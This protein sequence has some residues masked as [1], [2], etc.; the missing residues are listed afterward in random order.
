[1]ALEPD[2]CNLMLHEND[3]D[4]ARQCS[5]LRSRECVSA[6]ND[7]AQRV[8]QSEYW[9]TTDLDRGRAGD[10]SSAEADNGTASASLSGN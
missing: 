10:R 6:A 8:V 9:D 7:C 4:L 2:S 3:V 5:S 1:M